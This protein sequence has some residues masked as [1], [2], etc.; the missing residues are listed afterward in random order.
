ML[1]RKKCFRLP[2]PVEVIIIMHLLIH[3]ETY[4]CQLHKELGVSKGRASEALKRLTDELGYLERRSSA[5]NSRRYYSI[6]PIFKSRLM[7]RARE[8][9]VSFALK[10]IGDE[11]QAIENFEKSKQAIKNEVALRALKPLGLKLFRPLLN[12]YYR[13]KTPYTRQKLVELFGSGVYDYFQ[14]WRKYDFLVFNLDDDTVTLNSKGVEFFCDLLEQAYS[15][16]NTKQEIST[17]HL[18]VFLI[19]KV[20]ALT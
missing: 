11:T 20:F 2:E 3:G 19:R 13:D 15:M 18:L 16:S 7:E 6:K 4:P 12:S 5:D 14:E 10:E 9:A 17:S 8:G 1:K